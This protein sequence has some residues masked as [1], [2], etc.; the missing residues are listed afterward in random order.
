VL[1]DGFSDCEPGDDASRKTPGF[2]KNASL[3]C[4]SSNERMPHKLEVLS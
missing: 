4:A 1:W 2:A 3:V